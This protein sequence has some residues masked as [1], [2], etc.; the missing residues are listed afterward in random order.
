MASPPVSAMTWN[1]WGAVAANGSRYLPPPPGMRAEPVEDAGIGGVHG[2]V[3]ATCGFLAAIE[4]V[5]VLH[6]NSRPRITPK[7]GAA[8]SR[9]FV[10]IW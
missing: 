9:N 5:G 7:R 10:W 4:G 2:F 3:A 6:Q 8:Q 1:S